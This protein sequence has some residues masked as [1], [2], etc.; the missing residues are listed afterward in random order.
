MCSSDL[1]DKS[2]EAA[3]AAVEKAEDATA[4]APEDKVEE[5]KAVTDAVVEP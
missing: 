4:A 2:E 1:Q 5:A 3:T